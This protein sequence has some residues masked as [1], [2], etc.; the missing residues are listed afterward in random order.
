MR[1]HFSLAQRLA[2]SP[3]WPQILGFSSLTLALACGGSEH[4]SRAVPSTGGGNS[5]GG[6]SGTGQGGSAGS[7]GGGGSA[8]TAVG[9]T[10]GTG[11]NPG[12]LKPVVLSFTAAPATLPD[13]GGKTTLSWNVTG[14]DSLSI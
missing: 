6:V 2:C 12:A 13:G 1:W 14:A 8:G 3:R 10:S 7:I 4:G 11:S 5:S 9:G